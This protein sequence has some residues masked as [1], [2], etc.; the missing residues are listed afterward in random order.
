MVNVL[1]VS[2]KLVSFSYTID[3]EPAEGAEVRYTV[4]T[5]HRP[6]PPI[7]NLDVLV[8]VR[9]LAKDQDKTVLEA[10]CLTTFYVPDAIIGVDSEDGQETL[11]VSNV[12]G[13]RLTQEAISH[14][15]AL[16]A[17]H[18]S[19]TPFS[20]SHISIG[21]VITANELKQRQSDTDPET[22]TR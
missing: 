3:Y 9:Y 20:T 19:A 15:R 12:Q 5:L 16:I 11:T 21:E 10:S 4:E 13:K 17:I 18:T 14:A 8:N 2:I 6:H 22:D 1:V 7:K